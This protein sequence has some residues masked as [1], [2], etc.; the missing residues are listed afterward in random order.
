MRSTLL[1]AIF[2]SILS[3]QSADHAAIAKELNQQVLQLRSAGTPAD[4]ELMTRQ[5]VEHADMAGDPEI[6][7]YCLHNRALILRE[8]HRYQE[9]EPI[10]R[11]VLAVLESSKASPR[12]IAIALQTLAS[13]LISLQQPSDAEPLLL[14]AARFPIRQNSPL[15]LALI[16]NSL[17]EVQYVL[18]KDRDAENTFKRAVAVHSTIPDLPS[19]NEFRYALAGGETDG[20]LLALIL[21][22]Q[23]LVAYR[24]G[25]TRQAEACWRQSIQLYGQTPGVANGA[26]GAPIA[27]LAELLRFKKQFAEASKLLVEALYMFDK[28][29]GPNSFRA[30]FILNLQGHV[31][32]EMGDLIQ[33][34]LSYERAL[35][36]TKQ[37]AGEW[38]SQAGIILSNLA[39][40]HGRQGDS[41]S[42][43][44]LFDHS[45]KILEKALGPAHPQLIPV[46]KG[47][48]ALLRRVGRSKDAKRIEARRNSIQAASTKS[49][50]VS[51]EDLQNGR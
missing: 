30:A 51:L 15:V 3:A 46:L 49:G 31:L 44:A 16:L 24:L 50:M 28:S 17:G 39:E 38:H 6:L 34:R 4:L 45:L 41:T 8:L 48:A 18:G 1:S 36:L 22:N 20:L 23:G 9:A 29:L 5:A 43:L 11:R 32:A 35:S 12:S 13:L 7:A 27:N 37:F 25:Q 33:A 14:R 2:V 19:N 26:V 10:H 47:Q 42:A 21:N 40:L